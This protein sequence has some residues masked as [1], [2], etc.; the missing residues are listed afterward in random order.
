MTRETDITNA[1]AV[2]MLETLLQWDYIRPEDV[3]D[4]I[5]M[6]NKRRS[7]IEAGDILNSLEVSK[8]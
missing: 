5:E 3:D 4:V 7:A 6:T 2:A 8:T 1:G